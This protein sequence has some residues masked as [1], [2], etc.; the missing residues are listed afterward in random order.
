M[1]FIVRKFYS[2]Y[3][4]YE[5]QADNEDEAYEKTKE[6]KIDEREIIETLEEWKECDESIPISDD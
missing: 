6:L 5:V 2:G 4:T 1:K 3:C